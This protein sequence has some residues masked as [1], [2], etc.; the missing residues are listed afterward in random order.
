MIGSV[1]FNFNLYII[2]VGL[3]W[4]PTLLKKGLMNTKDIIEK[5][6]EEDDK[7]NHK[8]KIKRTKAKSKIYTNFNYEEK[9]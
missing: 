5:F 3:S 2:R 1:I 9:K 6:Y 8:R 4:F 7:R